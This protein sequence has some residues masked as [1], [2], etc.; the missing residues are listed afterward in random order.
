MFSV[1]LRPNTEPVDTESDGTEERDKAH[2]SRSSEH[3]DDMNSFL[4]IAYH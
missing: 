2:Q 1:V 3:K 4:T